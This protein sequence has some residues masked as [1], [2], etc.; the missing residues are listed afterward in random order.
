MISQG[1]TAGRAMHGWGWALLAHAE[2][3]EVQ[4]R[5]RRKPSERPRVGP[6]PSDTRALKD[7][8]E[9]GLA[10]FLRDPNLL[11]KRPPGRAR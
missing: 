7:K 9:G 6:V 2:V 4:S 5:A 8:P 11:P 10:D 1:K 3:L